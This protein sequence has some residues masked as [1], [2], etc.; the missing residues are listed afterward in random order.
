MFLLMRGIIGYENA[1]MKRERTRAVRLSKDVH[2]TRYN[3]RLKPDLDTFIFTGEE[4]ISLEIRKS[5]R[6]ITLHAADLDIQKAELRIG[7]KILTPTISYNEHAETA[8]FSFKERVP[9]GKGKLTLIFAGILNDTMRGFYRSRYEYMGTTHHL[10]VTSLN[11]LMPVAH[12]CFDEPSHKS[13]FDVTPLSAGPTAISNTIETE[14]TEHQGGY[15]AIRFAPSPK[16]SSY[17]V[18]FI[19]GHFEH[20]EKKT[21]RGDRT[22]FHHARQKHQSEFALEVA[23][24]RIEFYESTSALSIRFR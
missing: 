17:L 7:P 13:I 15:K 3:I 16:M 11:R 6:S 12:S 24:K 10:A 5:A 1:R 8:T 19:V 4:D 22:R 2:A 9:K 14:I 18:A 20:I 21:E 23:V